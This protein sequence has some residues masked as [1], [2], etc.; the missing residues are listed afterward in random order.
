M[1][2]TEIS[3]DNQTLDEFNETTPLER[4]NAKYVQNHADL[5]TV[6]RLRCSWTDR[7]S[8]KSEDFVWEFNVN[9][10]VISALAV[11]FVVVLVGTGI[12]YWCVR[13][14]RIRRR[15]SLD[16]FIDARKIQEKQLSAGPAPPVPPR[17]VAYTT[18]LG[19]VE[20]RSN[21]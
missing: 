19:K 17:P 15:H 21:L 4:I 11:M 10:I 6:C 9:M 2:S 1:T 18:A 3:I 5:R 8:S 16:T 7:S 12:W 14:H 20:Y 13:T